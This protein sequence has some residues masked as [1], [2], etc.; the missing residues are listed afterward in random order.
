[1]S[2]LFDKIQLRH[3]T[4]AN[5]T[6][7]NP[8]LLAGEIGVETDTGKIKVGDGATAW[9]SLA[10]FTGGSVSV[11]WADITGK[12]SFGTASLAD[13]SDF[14]T[15]AQGATA[16]SA[17]QPGDL[18]TVATTGAYSDLSGL[19]TLGTAAATDATDYAT[20]LQGATA[21]S[22][23][24]PDDLATVATTGAYSDLS[25]L[26]TLGSAAAEDAS[27]FATAAQGALADSAIQPADLTAAISAITIQSKNSA[28]PI[29]LTDAGTA[30]LH[31][32]SDTTPRTFTIPA[33]ASVAFPVGSILTFIN[34]DSAGDLTIAIT[35]DTLRLAGDGS[36]GSRTLA[37]NGIAT[38]T[39]LTSTE[40][41]I[42]GTGLT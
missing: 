13:S 36:T 27:A 15:A 37:A 6:S 19:P 21:D 41:I 9:A 14:A 8:T 16:D 11:A 39:K 31:P 7:A 38:A 35:S 3:D 20:A 32:S 33:N 24:Q 23:V 2:I 29:V 34:Q 40:W 1:M 25:G 22:A 28:Y 18:A 17:V 42:N 10:Y 26:P 30:L 12:P 5:W 4:A